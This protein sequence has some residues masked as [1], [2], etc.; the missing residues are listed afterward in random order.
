MIDSNEKKGKVI[1]I[2]SKESFLVK[3]LGTKLTDND[4]RIGF[5][6]LRIK[7]LETFSEEAELYI[8]LADEELKESANFLVYLKDVCDENERRIIFAGN[9]EEYEFACEYI[10]E[11]LI[12][13]WFD[14]PLDI[15]KLIRD[16]QN[17]IENFAGENRKKTI[18]IVD[19]DVTYMKLIYSW[20]K[21]YYHVAMANSG[22]QAFSW[23]AKNKADLVLLDYAMPIASG[24]TV[25]K[26]LKSES[27]TDS[28][29]V[30]FLTGKSD[31]ESLMSV[32]EL[33]PA[34]YLLKTIDKPTL[35]QKLNNFFYRRY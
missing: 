10:P 4:I 33:H 13:E 23:L 17:Y 24:A 11:H 1:L 30:M 5:C 29:P 34:D 18:L 15:P 26:M 25:M 21:D 31:K 6:P 12:L 19:D 3:G 2:S 35:L 14:R 9:P 28:I 8:V 22:A 32:I 20:L 7:M 16:T 27:E